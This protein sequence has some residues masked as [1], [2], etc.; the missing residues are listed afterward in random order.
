[1]RQ[2]YQVKRYFG[3]ELDYLLPGKVGN[4]GRPT[5]IRDLATGRIIR[6]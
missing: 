1:V 6:S 4:S 3:E 2:A 5:E